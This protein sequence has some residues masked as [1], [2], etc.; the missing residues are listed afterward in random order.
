MYDAHE[1]AE[2]IAHDINT[3]KLP[4]KRVVGGDAMLDD[5]KNR[6][7]RTVSYG[8]WK[9]LEAWEEEQGKKKGKPREKVVD[10]QQALRIIE[11]KE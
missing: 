4:L 1:T 10:L 3:R 8:D 6:G 11:G 7:V 5:L 9:R 2:S